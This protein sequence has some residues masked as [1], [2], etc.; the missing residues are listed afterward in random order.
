MKSLREKRSSVLMIIANIFF[1]RRIN[2]KN[3]ESTSGP[4]MDARWSR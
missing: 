1:E 3:L 4:K 2:V